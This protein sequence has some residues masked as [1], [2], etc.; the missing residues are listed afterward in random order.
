M[1][2]QN[3]I[4]SGAYLNAETLA[5]LRALSED[6]MRDVC[7]IHRPLNNAVNDDNSPADNAE[8]V[9]TNIK[10]RYIPVLVRAEEAIFDLRVTGELRAIMRFPL[11]T[12][13]VRTDYLLYNARQYEIVGDNAGR[14]FATSIALTLR[15]VT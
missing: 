2:N 14:T 11:G 13:V 7:E 6:T 4:T 9:Q 3:S 10:C 15:Q 8:Y 12:D 1:V 5:D